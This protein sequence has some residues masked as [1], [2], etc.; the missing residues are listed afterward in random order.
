MNQFAAVAG[1]RISQ[2]L[3]GMTSKRWHP[4]TMPA[5]QVGNRNLDIPHEVDLYGREY[6]PSPC[7]PPPAAECLEQPIGQRHLRAMLLSGQ[8][9]LSMQPPIEDF[10]DQGL[11]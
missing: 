7:P 6:P 9:W 1:V 5:G 10:T 4:I 8:A 11:G 2:T 3:S